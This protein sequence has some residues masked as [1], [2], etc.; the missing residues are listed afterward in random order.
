MQGLF[1]G[2]IKGYVSSKRR[3]KYAYFTERGKVFADEKFAFAQNQLLEYLNKL[4]K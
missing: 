4:I 1:L 3:S 2:E